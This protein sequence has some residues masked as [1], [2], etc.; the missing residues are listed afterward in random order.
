MSTDIVYRHHK[1]RSFGFV[2]S[3]DGSLTAFFLRDG[4]IEERGGAPEK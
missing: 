1:T 3:K 2:N 4:K